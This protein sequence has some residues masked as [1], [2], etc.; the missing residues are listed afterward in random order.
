LGPYD[1]SGTHSR[2]LDIFLLSTYRDF[3]AS[4]LPGRH[5]NGSVGPLHNFRGV[6]YWRGPWNCAVL[7]CFTERQRLNGYPGT[8]QGGC[9]SLCLPGWNGSSQENASPGDA[10]TDIVGDEA[11]GEA[12][13]GQ[14]GLDHPLA[15]ASIAAIGLLG[16]AAIEGVASGAFAD[17][18]GPSGDI[19]GRARLGES[20]LFDINANS[21]LRIGWGWSGSASEGTNVFRISGSLQ[22]I[23]LVDRFI[24]D[25]LEYPLEWDDFISWKNANESV[26]RLRNQFADLEPSLMSKD[27]TLRHQAVLDII[28][29]A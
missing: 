21:F 12:T 5:L 19:F 1:A 17:A 20:S 10:G 23:D 9:Y 22:A 24:D 15:Y 28:P 8:A 7:F 29:I 26:E 6:C 27:E 2:R 13:A 11:R 18:L 14:F 25:K 4:E 3:S 16:P